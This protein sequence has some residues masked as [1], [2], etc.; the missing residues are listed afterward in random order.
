M[1]KSVLIFA[2]M[3]VL[4][5][6][7][8]IPSFAELTAEQIVDKSLNRDAGHNKIVEMEMILS[9]KSSQKKRAFTQWQF[10]AKSGTKKLIRFTEPAQMKGTAFLSYENKDRDD[11]QW[12]YMASRKSN[13]RIASS[14]KTGSFVGSDLTYEDLS[15]QKASDRNH[16]I[17]ATPL[18]NGKQ[19]W[20]IESTIKPGKSTGYEKTRTWVQQDNFVALKIE[21]YDKKGKLLKVMECKDAKQIDGIWTIMEIK[22]TTQGADTSTALNIKS[23][24]YDVEVDEAMFSKDAMGEF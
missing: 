17:V 6:V 14:K 9:K 22:M 23:I 4:L 3:V 12:L 21:M 24:K 2:L 10:V 1:K 20:L 8:S 5:F 7:F 18:L 11:D 15:V 16:A 19:T 13:R